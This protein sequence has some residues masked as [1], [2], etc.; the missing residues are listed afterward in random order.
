MKTTTRTRRPDA[1]LDIHT[2]DPDYRTDALARATAEF[3]RTRNA[4]VRTSEGWGLLTIADA[5]L[6]DDVYQG[7]IG[8]WGGTTYANTR[9]A[10]RIL[11]ELDGGAGGIECA[12]AD[13][14]DDIVSFMDGQ[15]AR[16]ESH[17]VSH[18]DWPVA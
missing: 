16:G 7:R 5:I 1:E 10:A 12:I 11:R 4:W 8:G 6:G 15:A 18:F 14:L 13:R 3:V 2:I 9:D 17:G